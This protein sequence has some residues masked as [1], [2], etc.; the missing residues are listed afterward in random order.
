[1]YRSNYYDSHDVFRGTFYSDIS[2]VMDTKIEVIK[3]HKS[4]LERVRYEWVDFFSRQNANDGQK[5]G[6]NFS[7][8]FE[9]IRFLI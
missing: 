5:I 7:E 6:V 1:M 9:V 3:A 2:K 4:E 8:C